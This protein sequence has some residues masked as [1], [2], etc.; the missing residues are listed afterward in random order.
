[1]CVYFIVK[2]NESSLRC[3]PTKN[4][5]ESEC[6]CEGEDDNRMTK[7]VRGGREG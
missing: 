7:V 2:R 3:H 5:G 6:E 1:M 4:I